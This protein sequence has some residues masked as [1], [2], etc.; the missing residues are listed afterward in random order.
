MTKRDDPDRKYV[1]ISP[2]GI[3]CICT[4]SRETAIVG[5]RDAKHGIVIVIIIIIKITKQP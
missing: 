1:K 5:W 3:G 4:P 2:H